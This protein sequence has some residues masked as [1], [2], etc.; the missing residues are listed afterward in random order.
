MKITKLLVYLL[1]GIRLTSVQAQQATIASGGM[2]SS[3]NGNISYSFGQIDYTTN[4]NLTGSLWQGVQQPYEIFTLG[5]DDF[6][7]ISLKMLVYPNPTAALVN[8]KIESLSF[9]TLE[10]NL[11]DLMGKQISS[12][13]INQLETQ[14]PLENLPSTT[15][16]L[17]VS[18]NSQIIK[19]FKI[20]KTN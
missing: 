20:I 15:Y 16:I 5:T 1:I 9:N 7:N 17:N 8:L 19:S 10:Y 13:K 4:S 11:F 12:Q 6:Q 2:A 14:I 18:D 3:V